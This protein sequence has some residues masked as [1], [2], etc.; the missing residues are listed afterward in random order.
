MAWNEPGGGNHDPW[1][2]GN[3]GGGDQGPPDLDELLRKLSKRLSG[4][5]G[6]GGGRGGGSGG[7]GLPMAVIGLIVVVL[8]VVWAVAGV[9]IVNEGKRGVVLRFGGFHKVTMPGPHWRPFFI[10]S[11]ETV[12]VDQ[13]R[14]VQHR[15]T[16]LTQDENIVY[17]DLATQ[18][19]VSEA[20]D[21]LFNVRDP[22]ITVSDVQESSLREV[23]GKNRMDFV[24]GEGRAQI[25]ANTQKLMQE[26][27]QGY[28][29]GVEIINVNLQQAQPPEPV[30]GA[31][32]DA[33]KARE[34]E[35]RFRNEAEA[36]ANGI[37]P[38]ARGEAARVVEEANAYKK[39][40]LARAEGQT[41][42]F[43][44]LLVEYQQ[45]PEILRERFYLE[46]MQGV[47]NDTSKVMVDVSSGNNLI[48]LPVDR[49]LQQGNASSKQ[50]GS[51][52]S[53]DAGSASSS[54]GSS[55]ASSTNRFSFG[56]DNYD[57]RSREV[58]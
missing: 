26:M 50:S 27:L 47:L 9:Y 1:S 11:V 24:L 58:R 15:A 32:E 35:V 29:T 30:Q 52:N 23:V 40:V 46:T 38:K 48:Y 57:P 5:F 3:R 45:A 49:L 51:G 33:V 25:A 55:S 39:Q 31:F 54:A 4:I 17:I 16:M 22:D 34:D 6:G 13:I 43:E 56:R 20:N 7:A 18:Y 2:G 8:I 42:R 10:D 14:S 41:A 53:S 37:L 44:K 28:T 36:Y 12:D 19:R 21:Y